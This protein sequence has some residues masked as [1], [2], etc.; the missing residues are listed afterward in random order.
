M[1]LQNVTIKKLHDKSSFDINFIDNT[2][3]L[4]AENGSGKTTIVNMIYFFL[5]RQWAKLNEYQFESI[6]VTINGEKLSFKKNDLK[7]SVLRNS[8]ILE[9]I[10]QRYHKHFERILHDFSPIELKDSPYIFEKLADLYEIP[11]GYLREFIMSYVNEDFRLNIANQVQHLDRILS[12]IFEGIQIVYLPTYRRIEKDLKNI[13]PELEEQMK[14]YEYKRRRKHNGKEKNEYI[15]L[16]EFGMDDVKERVERVCNELK[17]NFYNNLGKKTGAY[18]ED[19]LHNKY[20]TFD[21]DK[22][23]HFNNEALEYLL[24]RLDDNI[25]SSN[26]KQEL[27]TFVKRI[28]ETYLVSQEDKIKAYFVWKLF[29]IY[30]EQQKAEIRVNRFVQICNDYVQQAKYLYYDNDN[31]KVDIIIN[32]NEPISRF[33]EPNDFP[34]KYPST[35]GDIKKLTYRDLS[36]GEKQIVSLFSHLIFSNKKY[37]ILID[38]PELSLSVPW[39]KRFLEDIQNSGDCVGLLAVTH[40][41]FIFQNNLK[42]YSHSLEE[43]YL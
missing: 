38:E 34:S 9:R 1:K 16:V 13:F 19:I 28:K 12:E 35:E 30:D 22:I 3:I 24:K 41:P 40:S 5:S 26:G 23:Q 17:A 37:F 21:S 36:S 10:P 39:Q 20:E 2:M 43:F 14:E 32:P 11:L 42:K 7:S 8:A 25:I 15:E 6:Q 29:Q 18:L 27:K 33:W 4:V 31:F